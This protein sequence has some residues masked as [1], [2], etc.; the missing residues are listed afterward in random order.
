[1]TFSMYFDIDYL[2][3]LKCS[4][5]TNIFRWHIAHELTYWCIQYLSKFLSRNILNLNTWLN[6]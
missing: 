5:S 6:L 4:V 1:L 2:L 3:K